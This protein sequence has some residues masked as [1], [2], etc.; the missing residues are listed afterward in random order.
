M[1]DYNKGKIYKICSNN[2][3]IKEVYYGST[4]RTLSQ[5]MTG[6]RAHYKKWI[7]EKY[8]FSPC[9]ICH[10]FKQYGIEQFHIELVLNYPC[11]NKEEL[12]MKENEYIREYDCVNKISSYQSVEERKEY[13][14]ITDKKWRQANKEHKAKKDKE[15]AE[16][17]KEKIAEYQKKWKEANKEKMREYFKQRHEAKKNK[18]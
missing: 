7:N 4:I 9:S 6:H 12:L 1:P 2:P 16:A 18:I 5:R 10:F 14:H 13:K 15:Y 11:E 17:N 8:S 3:E